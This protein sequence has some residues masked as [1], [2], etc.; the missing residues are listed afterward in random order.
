VKGPTLIFSTEG[1]VDVEEVAAR[2][3]E[4]V[5]TIDVDYSN[6]LDRNTIEQLVTNLPSGFPES[7]E[8]TVE[9]SRIVGALYEAFVKTDARAAEINPLVLTTD[10]RL[11]AA[12]CRF[13]IDD[14]SVYR[15]PEFEIALPRDMTREPTELERIAWQIEE[16]DYR[17]TGYFTQMASKIEGPGWIGLHGIGGGGSMIAASALI[18][19][20]FKIADYADTSGDPTASKVYRVI[21]CIL[22]QPIDAYVLMGA[23]LANQEQWHH[24]HAIVKAFREEA[25]RRPGFP[26]IVLLAG[27]KERETHEIIR[28]GLKDLPLRWEVYGREY[29]YRTEFIADRVAQLVAEYQSDKAR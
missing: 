2:N 19:R 5:V 16:E 8:F 9:L 25:S 27:N 26:V 10:G 20:G 1:G 15:H 7:G 4:R 18:A 28:R 29:I 17:G 12:D 22:A 21:K 24:G 14:N 11:C 13:T 3:P 6:G 23:C